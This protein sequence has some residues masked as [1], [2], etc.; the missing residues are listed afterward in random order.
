VIVHVDPADR[1]PVYEQLRAQIARMVAAGTLLPGVRLPTIRQLA[2]DLGVA[3]GTVAKA[4]EALLRDEL[5]VADGRRGTVVRARSPAASGSDAQQ[6]ARDA[7]RPLAVAV[8]QLGLER[9]AAHAALDAALD[10]LGGGT[11]TPTTA[12]RRDVSRRARPA[13]PGA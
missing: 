4:Y 6:A 7:A 3:K 9:A 1:T 13:S 2:A 5:V 12:S 10:E 11:G 8:H